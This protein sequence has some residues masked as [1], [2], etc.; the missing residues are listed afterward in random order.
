MNACLR[1]LTL[2]HDFFSVDSW[3][4]REEFLSFVSLTEDELDEVCDTLRRK[5]GAGI[6]SAAGA[7]RKEQV[8]RKC[9]GP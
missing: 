4:A 7:C 5:Y 8:R 1:S 6:F 2:K 9:G 3:F